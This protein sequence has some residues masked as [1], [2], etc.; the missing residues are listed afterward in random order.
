MPTGAEIVEQLNASME[1]DSSTDSEQEVSEEQEVAEAKSSQKAESSSTKGSKEEKGQKTV[2]NIPYDRFKEKVDQV[3]ELT[4]KLESVLSNS[5]S[6][7]ARETELREKIEALEEEADI[8]NRVRGL[9][10]NEKYRPLVE[11]LDK[12]LKGIDEDVESGA[13]TEDQGARDVTK[14]FGEQR[15]ELAEAFAD[16]RADMLLENARMVSESIL[17]SLPDGYD[18]GDKDQI[19]EMLPDLVDW[20]AIEE[21]PSLMKQEIVEGYKEALTQYG[22]PRGALKARISELETKSTE[23]EHD[24]EAA[25][26]EFVRGILDNERLSKFKTDDDGNVTEPE[27]SEAEFNDNFAEVLKRVYRH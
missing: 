12:A 13:K 26:E 14:L 25:D 5:E 20:N 8:L 10:E 15:E 11:K 24:A 17:D 3:A 9:A 2:Q 19:A 23:P 6:T 21:N 1:S 22:E 18:D 27:M 4:E 7:T 16:Q